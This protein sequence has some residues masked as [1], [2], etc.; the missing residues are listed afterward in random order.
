MRNKSSRRSKERIRV[1]RLFSMISC[2]RRCDER[3]GRKLK[4]EKGIC[5]RREL[6]SCVKRGFSAR[7][8]L[9]LSRL[10]FE[11]ISQALVS[12]LLICL[13][14]SVLVL[15]CHRKAIHFYFFLYFWE[16]ERELK[17]RV[18]FDS[19]QFIH[20]FIHSMQPFWTKPPLFVSL[21]LLFHIQKH[22][23]P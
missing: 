17:G 16:E 6:K 4:N 22:Q 12:F 19:I 10:F 21:F 5:S 20:S 23:T 11:E 3:F 13:L 8:F 15:V 18:L 9:F 7:F 1:A 2:E 14:L